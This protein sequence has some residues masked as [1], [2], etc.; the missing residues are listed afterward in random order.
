LDW[1][2][3]YTTDREPKTPDFKKSCLKVTEFHK[4]SRAR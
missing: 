4:F 1:S 2:T 3:I